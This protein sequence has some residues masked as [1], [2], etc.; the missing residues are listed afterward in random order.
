MGKVVN[1]WAREV[2]ECGGVQSREHYVSSGIFTDDFI[3]LEGL[4]FAKS[5]KV[6]PKKRAVKKCLCQ[7]HNMALSSYDAEAQKVR[8]HLEY[9]HARVEKVM[10]SAGNRKLIT[11]MKYADYEFFCRWT[12]KTFIN[13]ID[14]FKYKPIVDTDDLARAVFSENSVLDYV[15]LTNVMPQGLDFQ[16]SQIV[17]VSP[18]EKDG[19]TIGA[20]I[21]FCGLHFSMHLLPQL[22]TNK[23][24]LKLTFEV[25]KRGSAVILKMK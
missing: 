8:Q 10:G 11:H 25:P 12:L 2:S 22:P 19:A 9:I 24:K 20:D 17:Q 1:C 16:I 18:L 23:R 4:S 21:V 6:I 5:G 7:K 13:F 3:Y 15:A 14:D